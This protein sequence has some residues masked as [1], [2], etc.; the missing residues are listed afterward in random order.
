MKSSA[1]KLLSTNGP[2]DL[3]E[4]FEFVEQDL[5]V[6]SE[7][8]SILYPITSCK[9]LAGTSKFPHQVKCALWDLRLDG[10]ITGDKKGTW[11]VVNHPVNFN[12]ELTVINF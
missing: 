6:T 3:K 11:W 4:I 2:K 8:L 7:I 12:D 5:N 9:R 10:L 1:L